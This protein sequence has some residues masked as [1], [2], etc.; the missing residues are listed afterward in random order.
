[1]RICPMRLTQRTPKPSRQARP[2]LPARQR[3]VEVT[4]APPASS[5]PR[6][7]LG[8]VPETLEA[9][10]V[11]TGGLRADGFYERSG[12]RLVDLA[13]LA[14]ALP[15]ACAVA[16]PI[17][18]WNLVAFKD[19]RKVFFLQQ[20][21]GHRGR[22]FCIYK[23]RT[24]RSVAPNEHGAWSIEKDVLR[25]TRFGRLLRNTH[26]DELP[27][28]INIL[29][30]DMHLVGPRPEMVDI[31]EWACAEIPGFAKRLETPPGLTG[32][33]QITQGYTVRERDCY[34]KKLE[35]DLQYV[36]RTSFR[37]DLSII[38]RTIPWVLQGRGWSWLAH[39]RGRVATAPIVESVTGGEP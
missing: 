8:G 13:L 7:P 1:M 3:L 33:A 2:D 21:V 25:T 5:T 30:G 6:A 26:L 29:K 38:A 20:R 22:I 10:A 14:V 9:V 32:L 11:D 28:L 31:H 23:F 36:T 37:Q 35:I 19:P 12:K 27:Q 18:A 39:H 15:V 34:A 17:A 4:A 16:L 24:M